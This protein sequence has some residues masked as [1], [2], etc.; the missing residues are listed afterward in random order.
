MA[1]GE[2]RVSGEMQ[3]ILELFNREARRARYE[4]DKLPWVQVTKGMLTAKTRDFTIS[5]SEQTRG[6]WHISLM[7]KDGYSPPWP[8]WQPNL[9]AAKVRALLC[10]DEAVHDLQQIEEWN[11]EHG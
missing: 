7:H 1:S 11:V 9:E 4:A 8:S 3:L 2:T 10:V 6:R 5:L